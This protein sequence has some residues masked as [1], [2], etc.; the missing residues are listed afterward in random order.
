MLPRVRATYAQHARILQRI[1]RGDAEA[2]GAAMREH[3]L[4]SKA[5]V[6]PAVK[7]LLADVY[8]R[9]RD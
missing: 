7:A 5:N 4:E 2:A 3:I 9:P 8:L 6:I 1:A